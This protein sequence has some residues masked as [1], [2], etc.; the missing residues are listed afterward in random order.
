MIE[1]FGTAAA[2][3]MVLFYSLEKRAPIY[4]LAFAVSCAAAAAYALAIGAYPFFGA[5]SV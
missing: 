1:M 2:V 3:P 5:E 4:T